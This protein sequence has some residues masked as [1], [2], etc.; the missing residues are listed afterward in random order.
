MAEWVRAAED[1][2]NR[3]LLILASVGH[4][5]S[6]TMGLVFLLRQVC[7]DR[8]RRWL[9]TSKKEGGVAKST[10]KLLGETLRTNQRLIADFGPFYAPGLT[11]SATAVTILGHD[12]I[13]KDA[14][15]LAVGRHSSFE[16]Y[17]AYGV[18][19]D[20]PFDLDTE[21]HKA[22][23]KHT[24]DWWLY[25][26]IPRLD[27]G[28]RML[29][30]GS[31][32]FLGDSWSWLRSRP[33]MKVLEYPA[34]YPDGRLLWPGRSEGGRIVGWTRETL[35]ERRVDV[36]S[37]IFNARY[38]LRPESLEGN[39]FKRDWLRYWGGD[40]DP[41]LPARGRLIVVIGADPATGKESSNSL[42]SATVLARDLDSHLIF[43]ADHHSTRADLPTFK[44]TLQAMVSAWRPEAGTALEDVG[45]QWDA[46]AG[47]EEPLRRQ[48]IESLRLVPSS[49]GG[50]DKLRRIETLAPPMERGEF[51][52]NLSQ[53]DPLILSFLNFPDSVFLD[54]PDSMEHA[55]RR[56]LEWE[57]RAPR[58][59]RRPSVAARGPGRPGPPP[60]AAVLRGRAPWA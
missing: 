39:R 51:L 47:T 23:Q 40:A 10:V 46:V 22:E 48:T 15:F 17:R 19:A 34:I 29:G 45:F 21:V 57:S 28:G 30:V 18:Y 36:G 38:L 55:Y 58:P 16:G 26:V 60:A 14:T 37:N 13:S 42:S 56:L 1:P 33:G 7:L 59:S 24:R 11:W 8:R 3:S 4:G 27:A 9:V 49:T 12:P 5:K 35:E 54:P 6:A 41:K 43:V 20:D 25:S 31:P 50:Q 44:K 52:F 53:T 32:Y 2:A